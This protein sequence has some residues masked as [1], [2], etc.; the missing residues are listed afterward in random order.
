VKKERIMSD[1]PDIGYGTVHGRFLAGVLDDLDPVVNPTPP[2]YVPEL[3]PDAEPLSGFVT[4]SATAPIIAVVGA[5]PPTTL[6]P[7]HVKVYL[8]DEGYLS[9]NG[10]RDVTLWATDDPDGN[11]VDWQW[12]VAFSLDH[13]GHGIYKAPFNFE[14]PTGSVV[15]LTSVAPIATPSPGTVIIQ[16]PP[17]EKGDPGADSTV[18]GPPGEK[19][20]KG[21]KGDPGEP[22]AGGGIKAYASLAEVEAVRVPEVGTLHVANLSATFPALAAVGS[23]VEDVFSTA[24]PADLLITTSVN[25]DANATPIVGQVFE[26]FTLNGV[27][28]QIKR[29]VGADFPIDTSWLPAAELPDTNTSDQIAVTQIGPNGVIWVLKPIESGIA[30][31]DS[32]MARNAAGQSFIADPTSL[33]H[34][35]NKR[36]VDLF[37]KTP[38]GFAR[39]DLI[40][41]GSSGPVRL[42]VPTADGMVLTADLI[43]ANRMLWKQPMQ[44]P[45]PIYEWNGNVIVVADYNMGQWYNLNAA[46]P[47]TVE[48]PSTGIPVGKS[49]IYVQNGDGPVTFVAGAGA[50]LKAPGGKTK[51]AGQYSK[52]TLTKLNYEQWL[53]EGDLVVP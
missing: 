26:V 2:G 1:F 3:A 44:A 46:G 14:L 24:G 31:P 36:Y 29:T 34:V 47:I 30:T 22:G 51:L 35:A 50:I 21:D 53:I 20:D 25:N 17:G 52:A 49:V 45:W 40:V 11:P 38:P 12:H 19:G 33:D 6:F 15:D 10:S 18:P 43:Q 5:T 4:F 39:G 32:A 42:P 27:K 13:R 28:H 7:Q 37:V 48:V 9:I 16:G 41:R 8:D 23:G